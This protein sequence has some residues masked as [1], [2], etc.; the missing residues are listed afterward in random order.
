MDGYL[1]IDMSLVCNP[2]DF[3][4]SDEVKGRSWILGDDQKLLGSVKSGAGC[5]NA[6]MLAYTTRREEFAGEKGGVMLIGSCP[7]VGIAGYATGGG[8]GDTTPWVGLGVDDVLSYDIVLYNG[9][10]VTA[11]RTEHTDLYW[12]L[13]GGGSGIGVITQLE[14]AIVQS[15]DPEPGSDRK[16]TAVTLQYSNEEEKVKKFITRFQDFLVPPDLPFDSTEYKNKI[17]KGSARFGGAGSI[18]VKGAPFKNTAGFLGHFLGS[19]KEAKEVFDEYCLLDPEILVNSTF[20]QGNSY[21]D[22]QAYLLCMSMNGNGDPTNAQWP[23]WTAASLRSEGPLLNVCDDLGIDSEQF[24]DE[25]TLDGFAGRLPKCDKP[26]VIEA[27]VNASLK[28]QSFMNRPGYELTADY[29]EQLYGNP[30]PTVTL[31]GGLLMPRLEPD[32]LLELAKLGISIF[33]L[34]HGAPTLIA[35][36]E[37][38]YANREEFWLL[39]FDNADLE[40]NNVW[41][42]EFTSILTNKVYGGDPSKIRGFYNYVNPLGNPNWRE[43]YW[44]DNYERLSEIKLVYDETNGFGNP[45]QVEPA[46]PGKKKKNGKSGKNY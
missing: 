11:S 8:Q 46:I 41:Y 38:G 40:A 20:Y 18:G 1:V 27:I 29:F 14:T 36:E 30:I 10:S 13:R 19:E 32:V 31:K 44:G 3:I 45:V 23:Y 35:P 16:F 12:Y 25:L 39:A 42:N 2:E 4:V 33:H 34:A 24:C 22:T 28:P 5:T 15:P 43:Y 37:T 7:S 26:T 6:V 17:K 9:T 21:G